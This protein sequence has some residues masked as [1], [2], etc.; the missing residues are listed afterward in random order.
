MIALA[1]RLAP[2]IIGAAMLIGGWL[3]LDRACWSSACESYRTQFEY[4]RTQIE[5]AQRQRNELAL[6]WADA[7]Q[8][9]ERVYVESARVAA[10]AATGLRE[11]ARRPGAGSDVRIR[12]PADAVRVLRDVPSLAAGSPAARP[13]DEAAPTVSEAAD[14]TLSEWVVFAVDA[15]AAYADAVAKW[16]GVVQAYENLRSQ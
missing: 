6:K 4:A 8:K 3:Y 9:T 5:N 2:Y 12:V 11:R 16:R 13:V 1:L 10:D 14:T 15:A 7:I